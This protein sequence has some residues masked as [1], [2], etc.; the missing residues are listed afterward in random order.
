MPGDQV[1]FEP[2][3]HLADLSA[4]EALIA[5]GGFW[6]HRESSD[7]RWHI[8]DDEELSEV[9]GEP[10]TES[11]G[12]CSEPFG[13]AVV[14]VERDG[15]VV[16]R[17]ESADHNF[18]RVTDLEPDTQYR[19]R[20]LVDG[21]PWADGELWDWDVDEATLVRAGGSYDNRF[22]TF[23]AADVPVPVTFAVLG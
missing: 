9:A 6:F 11:I 7:D 20:V 5:W 15:E 12:A 14:E 2:F 23:P 10:R 22:R 19:Y 4:E 1:H 8:V 13:H 3:L 16:A 21:R 17:A 18:V